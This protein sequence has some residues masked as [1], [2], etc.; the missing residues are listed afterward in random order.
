V[1]YIGEPHRC[2]EEVRQ[3]LVL[4]EESALARLRGGSHGR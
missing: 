1:R 3:Q 4:H 2:S